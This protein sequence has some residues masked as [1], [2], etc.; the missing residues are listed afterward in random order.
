[1]KVLVLG[2][3]VSGKAAKSWLEERGHTV[4]TDPDQLES[5]DLLVPSPGIPPSD[6]TY[7]TAQKLGMPI[8]G[9]L[10]LFLEQTDLRCIGITGTNGKSTITTA[11]ARA[12]SASGHFALGVGNLGL[13]P[14]ALTGEQ[15]DVRPILVIEMSSFQLETI[16]A[17]SLEIAVLLPIT[18]DHLDRY[19][20]FADYRIAKERIA[21]C[22]RPGG[23]MVYGEGK[24]NEEVVR[25]VCDHF[26]VELRQMPSLPHRLEY[27]GTIDG[28]DYI[29]DSK[30]TNVAS[31]CYG[32]DQ[33]KKKVVL[34]AGGRDKGGDFE[35]LGTSALAGTSQVVAF[36]EAREKIAHAVQH[37]VAV[38]RVGTLD[39]ALELARQ[40]A[41]AGEV[42]LLS[43]GCSSFDAFEN[44][45]HRGDHFRTWVGD[46]L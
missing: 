45:E 33:M 24:T 39:E 21:G 7:A 18:P 43:P 28:V 5:C 31:V 46:R 6:L 2:M 26:G 4:V 13:P 41:Q 8:K 1:M 23:K 32:L 27:I 19:S 29:N 15:L 9:E 16:T 38:H 37:L 42:I 14:T 17:Q 40:C 20:S 34:L 11:I 30:A 22:L 3:G 10:Q 25:E 44:F 35:S 12:L 36:G